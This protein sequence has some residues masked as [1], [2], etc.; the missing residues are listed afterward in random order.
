MYYP[1]TLLG[2]GPTPAKRAPEGPQGLEWVG[3]GPGRTWDGGGDGPGPTPAGP[4]RSGTPSPP[5]SR[6][7]QNAAS[8]PITA[9]FEAIY[10][11]VSQNGQVSPKK[12]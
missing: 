7:S 12:W 6:T 8:W 5:W 1:A 2:E 3:V 4:G 11:K 10:C 9:R